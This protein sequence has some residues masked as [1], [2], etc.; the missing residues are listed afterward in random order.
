MH[1]PKVSGLFA[2]LILSSSLLAQS[3]QPSAARETDGGDDM[4]VL[5]PFVVESGGD[6]GYMAASTLAGTRLN[7][8]LKDVGAAVSVYTTEFLQDINVTKI[9]DILTYT[10]STEGGGRNGNFSGITGDSSAEVRENP[11]AVNR[12]RAL[13]TATR[14]RDFFP[15][16]IPSD[17]FSFDTVTVSRGPNAILAGVGAAGG[18]IDSALR[19]ATFKDSYRVVSRISSHSSHREELHFNKVIIPNRLALRLDVLRDEQ[20]FQQEP[21]F[22]LDKRLYAALTAKIVE[23]SP[24]GWLGRGTL[25]A[26]FEIG[27]I[28]GTP[29]DLL[30]PVANLSGWFTDRNGNP[31]AAPL[32]KWSANGATRQILGTDGTTVL[33][34]AQTANFVQGFPLYAQWAV[35]YSDPN[36]SVPGLGLTGADAAIQGFQGTIP[37][38]PTGPGGFVRGTGD[39]NRQR[40]GFFRT[41][42]SDPNIFNFYDYLLTGAFDFRQQEFDALDIRYE[43]LLFGGK[44]GFE[45]AINRQSFKTT[46]DIPIVNGDEADVYIDV[47]R[48]L[49]IRSAQYPNGI[50]N[51]NYGRP[52]VHTQDAFNDTINMIDRNSYQLTAFLRH[53]FSK[54][55]SKWVR[56]LGRHTLSALGFRT[57]IDK[58]LRVYRSTW[59]PTGQLNPA[60]NSQVPGTYPTQVNAWFYV[61][62]SVANANSVSDVRLQPIT[63]GR[64]EYGQSYTLRI[65]N[66]VTKAFE[67]GSATPVRTLG[68]LND[69]K[70]TVESV[71]VALQS[72]FLKD[73]LVTTVGWREDRDDNLTRQFPPKLPDGGYDDSVVIYNPSVTQAKRSWTKSIVGLLPVKLPGETEIRGFWNQSSNYNPVGQRRNIYNEELGSPSAETEEY[74]VS[75]STFNGK[76]VLKVNR[77]ETA[78]KNDAVSVLNPYTYISTMITRALFGRD[79]GLNPADWGYPGFASFSDVALAFYETIP[80]GLRA[81]IGDDKQF[82]PFFTG[83]GATLQW[84]PASIVNL[85]STSNTISKGMEY[86]AI[87]NPTKNWRISLSVAKN[88]AIKADVAKLELQFGEEWRKNLET[89]YGGRLLTGSRQPG[90]QTLT[91]WSQYDT[92]TLSRIRTAAALSG[93]ATPEVRKWRM[94]LVTNYDFRE[95]FL[96]GFNVGGAARWQDRVGIG[97]P[98]VK[99]AQNLDVADITKPY[100][101]PEEIA[102]D[103]S[104]GYR[105]KLKAFGQDVTWAISLNVRNLNAKEEIIPIQA[106]ADGTYGNF[107]IAPERTWSVTNSFSF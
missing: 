13:A 19:K 68:N 50:P 6:S 30:T 106:N 9:E 86:E 58:K 94:N 96:K 2:S 8:E 20:N 102:F 29:P 97:Y 28:K 66:N 14:T 39:V 11:S 21:A 17:G 63:T 64:P 12:V 105:R 90:V 71:A 95:G 34:A 89:M 101:G 74:G 92:E 38:S 78:I 47:T 69:Q 43:Q 82:K 53:D 51:P 35:V 49:S 93:T 72:H 41:H 27:K 26:N 55:E 18:V 65:Y 77:Y 46:R 67:T 98:L 16:D 25:R 23:G 32:L 1:P 37:V 31:L 10:A 81:N 3:T 75:I 4:I 52:F 56:M 59:S 62:D 48:I 60:L 80:Q 33:T 91:F 99:N 42:L 54:S 73:H 45:A 79:Q 83:S 88:E 15:S 36:S 103:A 104:V 61:G 85:T 76:L 22:A 40:P 5:S 107:R 70:E 84:T 7:T 57:E 24:N 44:A 100:W 87:I